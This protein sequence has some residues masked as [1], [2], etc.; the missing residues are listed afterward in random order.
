MIISETVLF[1]LRYK[2]RLLY[3]VLMDVY[4]TRDDIV[5]KMSGL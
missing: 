4:K 3:G 1:H 2:T 5:I